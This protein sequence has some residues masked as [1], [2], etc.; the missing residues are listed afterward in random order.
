MASTRLL[1]TSHGTNREAFTTLDWGRFVSLSLIWGSSF[2]FIAIGLDAFHPGLVTFLRVALG[3]AALSAIPRARTV[4]I[5]RSDYGSVGL[6]AAIWVAIPFTLF[7]IAQQW[8][9]SA[10][11]GMLN[12]ATPIFTAVIATALLRAFPGPLQVI[13]VAVGFVGILAI[14]LPSAGSGSTQA[15]GVGLVLIATLGYAVSLNIVPPLQQKY[16]SLP[17]MASVLKIA[18]PMVAPFGVI[19]AFDS[20]FAWPSLLA[21][22]AIGVLGTG[23]AF[24]LMGNL[25]GSVGAT[26]AS[27]MTYLLP[28]VAMVL[29]VVFRS[30]VISP[31]AVVGVLLVIAGAIL[32]SRRETGRAG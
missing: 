9:D 22:A 17:L 14:A 7:P 16:G 20:S 18:V 21:V 3:A 23:L 29:G 24:V 5:D 8:I 1:Q 2:L 30:E 28:V 13:G 6:L 11:A 19:G 27:V 12:G 31:V 4:K 26:R 10:V 15:L 32:A 25:T